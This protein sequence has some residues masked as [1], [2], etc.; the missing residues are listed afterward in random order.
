MLGSHI[1]QDKT[2]NSCSP[3]QFS[4][5]RLVFSRTIYRTRIVHRP[6][7]HALFQTGPFPNCSMLNAR[8]NTYAVDTGI[9]DTRP[10]FARSV[11]LTGFPS[12]IPV[13]R[14]FVE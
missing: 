11:K 5:L 9:E 3:A 14:A 8:H 12:Q 13:P 6:V 4:I 1:T 10:N 7:R 2:E